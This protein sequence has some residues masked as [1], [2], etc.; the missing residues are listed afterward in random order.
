MSDNTCT[1]KIVI[2]GNVL[3][4]TRNEGHDGL[5]GMV[6]QIEQGIYGSFHWGIDAVGRPVVD[7]PQHVELEALAYIIQPPCKRCG[8]PHGTHHPLCE[9]EGITDEGLQE[10]MEILRAIEEYPF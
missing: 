6:E 1:A 10:A 5:H 7:L 3:E 4:C 9:V 2:N 8:Y